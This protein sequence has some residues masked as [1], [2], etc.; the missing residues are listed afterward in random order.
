[1]KKVLIITYY[2]PPAGGPGVQRVLKFAKYLPDFGWEP[3]ILTVKNGEFP[4]HDKSLENDIPQNCH[5]HKSKSVEPFYIYKK[6]LGDI[7]K[8]EIPTYILNQSKSDSLKDKTAKWIRL[9]LFV[10]DA[11]IGWIPF[12][13]SKGNKLIKEH[14]IDVIFSSSPP[15]TVNLIAKKLSKKSGLPWVADY[16][17]PWT[18]AFWQE[19]GSNRNYFSQYIDKSLEQSCLKNANSITTV[20][21]SLIK[22]FEKKSSN[23]YSL[24]PNGFDSDDFDNLNKSRSEK[25]RINYIGYL[26]Q[27]QKID[28]FLEALSSMDKKLLDKMDINF[29]GNI[30]QS[31]LQKIDSFHLNNII[32]IKT[33]IPH[34]EA[35]KRMKCS[36]IL[37]LVIPDVSNNDLIVTGKLFEYLATQNYILGIGP[38]SGDVVKILQET[39]CGKMFDYKENLKDVLLEQIKKWKNNE[40][41]SVNINSIN[42][43]SRSV[44]TEKLAEIFNRVVNLQ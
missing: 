19:G 28:N 23:Q 7:N 12:A 16:R 15:Q 36:E 21:S 6:F 32:K 2:W 26:S 39:N 22:L 43:Y 44:L 35:I 10:P 3:F 34:D 17:D 8:N 30:H 1:M 40:M 4:A 29:Y 9:N 5:V 14:N 11:K 18:D 41:E 27:S 42:Q 37:L 31:I 33:Y 38:L 13:V 20:S 24:M 25:F